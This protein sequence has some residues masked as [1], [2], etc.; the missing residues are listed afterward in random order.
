MTRKRLPKKPLAMFPDAQCKPGAVSST[1][2]AQVG[3]AQVHEHP[4]LGDDLKGFELSFLAPRRYFV[5][6]SVSEGTYRRLQR[7]GISLFFEEA[8]AAFD[9]N[10]RNLILA[11]IQLMESRKNRKPDEAICNA[12]GRVLKETLQRIEDLQ[13]SLEGIRGVSRAKVLGGLIQLK[14][15]AMK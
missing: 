9:G 3:Q 13:K 8:V 1:L 7:Y 6:V 2:A 11:S 15:N 10:L 14:L 5:S 12:N 4:P